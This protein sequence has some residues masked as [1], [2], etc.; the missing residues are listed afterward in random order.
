MQYSEDYD[1]IKAWAPLLMEGRPR[2]EKYAAT[3]AAEGSDVDFGNLT[4]SIF[5]GSMKKGLSLY[6]SHTVTKIQKQ[7]DKSWLVKVVSD[8][9]GSGYK[10]VRAKFVCVGAGGMA[11][12]LLRAAGVSE[13][14]GYGAFP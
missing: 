2:D 7:K 3:Y 8:N 13:V 6:P 11:L 12:T 14:A 5:E 1:Q 4:R 10:W 9:M